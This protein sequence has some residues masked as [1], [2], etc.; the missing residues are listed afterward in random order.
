MTIANYKNVQDALGY[1][2]P[3]LERD[4]WAKIGMSLKDGLNGDGFDLFNEWSKGGIT[5]NASDTRDTWNS[6]KA[7]GGI[8]VGTLLYTAGQN[9]WIPDKTAEPETESE[10]LD[11][12]KLR[13]E[14]AANEAKVTESK[15]KA[16]IVK[17]ETLC[18][19]AKPAQDDH[20]Y[21]VRKGVKPVSSLLEIPAEQAV[22]ILG[23]TPKSDGK[24]LAGRLLIAQV[25]IDGRLS[26]AELIDEEG[27][28]SAIAGGIKSC[29]Y[30]S[31]KPLPANDDT[32][33]TFAIGEGVATILTA[34]EAFSS[35]N[36]VLNDANNI[37][38]YVNDAVFRELG[39]YFLAALSA[40]NIP[41][42]AKVILNRYPSAKI[43]ILA[44]VG[45]GQKYA[46]QAA[47]EINAAL[48]IPFFTHEQIQQF[49][50]TNKNDKPPTDFN[51]L[52]LI[53]GLDVVMTQI[54]AA[55]L[56]PIKT[57]ESKPD[58]DF[59]EPIF[60]FP[61]TKDNGQKRTTI[62]NL[63]FLFDGYGI[64]V[65]YDELLKKQTITLNNASD[66]GHGDL[67]DNSNIAHLRSLMA[68]NGLS[69]GALDLLSAL[70][71]ENASNPIIDW[72]ESKKW[73][74][75]DRLTKL[76]ETL[77]V[78]EDDQHYRDIALRTWLI[79]CVAATDG[80]RQTPNKDA[81]QKFELAFILQG[82]QGVK[83]TSW[84]KR[85]LPKELSAYIIDGAHLDP[86]DNETVKICISSWICELG[87]LDST[88]RRADIS[89]LKAFLSKQT[90]T[91]RLPYDRAA[92]PF[93]RRTSFC[94]SVNPEQ[95]LTDST[96]ARRFLPLQVLA[97]DSLHTIDMQQLWAQI[98][99]YYLE[100]WQ[101]WCSGELEH[102]LKARHERHSEAVPVNELIAEKFDIEKVEKYFNHKHYTATRILIEC[103]IKEPKTTQAN[104]VNI[105]LKKLGYKQIMVNGV[106]GFWLEKRPYQPD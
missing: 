73:D 82:G 1:I 101:W 105:Y 93:G 75:K 37:L 21:L 99:S 89:R 11:R 14:K 43:I 41:K 88:F 10:R 84:F 4:E 57:I 28:K 33:L 70:F 103:G 85:L 3:D 44:D 61:H 90:D 5:Y 83:K 19:D 39:F 86:A 23:Y 98:W 48:A 77:T 72:I 66:R 13:K 15:A 87:E 100:G 56:P 64:I 53:A 45:N 74:K 81:I 65:S 24:P 31:A 68:L 32:A 59:D 40:S 94:G 16:A 67:I 6:I 22:K 36:D 91:L 62:A 51:D 7:G 38:N 42:V 92:S 78:A 26:T 34:N 35:A 49:Q 96:G 76:S 52:H 27:R 9:G 58:I 17:V 79:Q 95:F 69:M 50:N 47:R 102:L 25:E 63:R 106:R 55:H 60:G 71:A 2:S 80:A 12:E 20:P 46:E 104:M 8:T 97:C 30:W 54:S 29:G 18:T